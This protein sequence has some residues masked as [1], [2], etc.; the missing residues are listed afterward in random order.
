MTLNNL[1]ILISADSIRCKEAE[2]FYTEA[3][4]IRRKLAVDNPSVYLPYVATTLNNLGLLLAVDSTH[5]KEAETLYTEALGIRL[6]LATDN[7]SVYLP[8]VA[9]TLGGFGLACLR[10][11]EPD[12]ARVYLQEAADTIQPFAAQH[13]SVYG[14]LQ[15][16]I[17]RD[18]AKSTEIAQ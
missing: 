8:Y 10:W 14:G 1:G 2:T 6:K 17:L 18:L 7:P 15:N 3:L 13:P 12:R 11:G 5:R 16:V 9:K 4:N